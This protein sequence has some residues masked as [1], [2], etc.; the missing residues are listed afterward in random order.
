MPLGNAPLHPTPSI[1][2]P[3]D[4]FIS[5][6]SPL[7]NIVFVA[8]AFSSSSAFRDATNA[9]LA[10]LEGTTLFSRTLPSRVVFY[11]F[12]AET[13]AHNDN[14]PSDGSQHQHMTLLGTTV[15][16]DELLNLDLDALNRVTA[17]VLLETLNSELRASLVEP[18]PALAKTIL[19]VLLPTHPGQRRRGAGPYATA[20][21][22]F[23]TRRLLRR[24][25]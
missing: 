21:R 1:L 16:S 17:S 9:I 10:L 14:G 22:S 23:R 19:V 3:L 25:R 11:R 7:L 5:A 12:W 6:S 24:R 13:N 15:D 8:E 18:G 2:A 4:T 20:T